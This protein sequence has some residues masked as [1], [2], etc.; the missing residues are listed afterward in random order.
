MYRSEILPHGQNGY[1]IKSFHTELIKVNT[2]IAAALIIM[3]CSSKIC[4]F[5][6]LSIAIRLM[7]HYLRITMRKH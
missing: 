7:Q 3:C 2:M 5:A 4:I 1:K 6:S